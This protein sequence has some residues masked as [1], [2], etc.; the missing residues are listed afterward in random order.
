[1]RSSASLSEESES[2]PDKSLDTSPI[3]APASSTVHFVSVFPPATAPGEALLRTSLMATHT[4][5]L[6]EEAVGII[7]EVLHEHHV[8]E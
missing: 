2:L 4:E 1:M 7:A 6:I 5:E 8:G 3:L